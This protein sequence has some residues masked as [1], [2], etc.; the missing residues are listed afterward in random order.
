MRLKQR[1]FPEP[2]YVPK[3]YGY[4]RVSHK[5]QHDRGTSLLDQET[6]IKAYYQMLLAQED[7]PKYEF[8]AIFAEPVAQSAYS[9]AFPNRPAGKELKAIL[10]PGDQVCV[11]KFDRL[12]RD[13]EDFAIHRRWF[14]ERGIGLHIVTFFGNAFDMNS[15]LADMVLPM[16]SA[17]AEM[18]SKIKSERITLARASRRAEGR[19]AGTGAPFFCE[20]VDQVPGK[21]RGGRLIISPVWLPIIEKAVHLKDVEGLGWNKIAQH[22]T[23]SEKKNIR[24]DKVQSMYAFWK[25]WNQLNRP[26]I[27]TFKMGEF[28]AAYWKENP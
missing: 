14:K 3:F 27:N 9:K 12:F 20:E 22:L 17:M 11:E 1:H 23:K 2:G 8:G 24:L 16:F 25:R 21:K 5:Q 13:L 28:I 26:D 18:E 19:S 6:R 15:T 4:C 10:R 7:K